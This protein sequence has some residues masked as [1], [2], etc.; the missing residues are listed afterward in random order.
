MLGTTPSSIHRFFKITFIIFMFA[1]LCGCVYLNIGP[2]ES[3][4][5]WDP[6]QQDLRGNC[7]LLSVGARN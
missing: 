2:T 1:S 4:K 3:G 6:F 5:V 7:E